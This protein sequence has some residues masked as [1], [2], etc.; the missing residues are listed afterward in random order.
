MYLAII[1]VSI[2]SM[3]YQLVH[4]LA[5]NYLH[6]ELGF[7]S[8]I[9]ALYIYIAGLCRI[10]ALHIPDLPLSEVQGSLR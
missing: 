2:C 8:R 7:L 5:L 10:H 9:V 4:D 6:S 1:P 3:F